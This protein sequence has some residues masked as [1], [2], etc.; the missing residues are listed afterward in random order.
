LAK[1]IATI[2]PLVMAPVTSSPAVVQPDVSAAGRNRA[3]SAASDSGSCFGD[4]KYTTTA[5]SP[6]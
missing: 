4:A 1:P 5:G 2:A 6:S 3:I